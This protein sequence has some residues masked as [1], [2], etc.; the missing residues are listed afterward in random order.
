MIYLR[1]LLFHSCYIIWILG[2]PILCMPALLLP[3]RRM[4]WAMGLFC[5]G[6]RFIEKYVGGITYRVEGEE[7]LPKDGRYIVGAKHQSSLET[8][9][10]PVQ[11]PDPA[12]ILKRILHYIP[13]WGWFLWKMDMIA[14]DRGKKSKAI[15]QI[16]E[17]A[18]R[19]FAQGRPIVI[20]P[21]G[22]RVAVG[23]YRPYRYG[24]AKLYE[25]LGVPVAPCALNTGLFWG[26]RKFLI[27][28]GMATIRYLPPIPPGLPPMEMLQKLEEMVESESERLSIEAGGPATRALTARDIEHSPWRKLKTRRSGA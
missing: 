9:I 10:M 18:R 23:D 11:L 21:Q 25:E 2:L 6:M 3:R 24:I 17:G 20:Y 8:F 12:I 22:T 28:P 7:H 19:C 16:V 4:T 13:F 27:H 26:R 14:V 5:G 15:Q 1:S